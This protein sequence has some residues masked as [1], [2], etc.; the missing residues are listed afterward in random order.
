MIR[1]CLLVFFAL[2]ASPSHGA[3]T[4]ASVMLETV[5][6]HSSFKIQGG[7]VDR[8]NSVAYAVYNATVNQTG[9]RVLS[10]SA[11]RS[12]Q[13]YS[14]QD[15]LY[16]AGLLEGYLT[17]IEIYEMYQNMY[18]T[19]L[20]KE[21]AETI[22]KVKDFYQEQRNWAATQVKMSSSSSDYWYY[23]GLILQ[24]FYGM[25]DGYAIAAPSVPLE[26]FAFDFLSGNGDFLDIKNFLFP[27]RRPDVSTMTKK[28]ITALRS[29]GHC[30]ALIKLLPG[31]E[32]V[33]AAHSSWYTYAA[34][35][36]IFKHYAFTVSRE[37]AATKVM[38]F[39]S[40]PGYLSSLDDFYIMDSGLIMLQTT[41]NI[42]NKTLYNAATP[43]A[44]LAW[45]RVRLANWL[46]SSGQEWAHY[47][48]QYNSGTY[49]NQYMVLDLKKIELQKAVKD[50]V[51]WV[52]EQIPGF[53][54]S[55]DQTAV[56]QSG[57]WAS[58]NVPFYED[59]FTAS[60]YSEAVAEHGTDMSYQLCPRAKIFRRDQGR[61]EDMASM[62]YIMRFN[63]YKNDPYSEGNPMNSIC[64]RG[65]LSEE[66]FLG[67]CYDTKVTDFNLAKTL[68]SFAENGPTHQNLP[69]FNWESFKSSSANIAHL[70]QPSLFNFPFVEMKPDF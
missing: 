37:T 25:V 17:H 42:F 43:K 45:H 59:I 66:P 47:I 33:F 63:D 10:V 23:T 52:V 41:N 60:G 53:V 28:Q 54:K 2:A 39:S 11:G 26:I 20:A 34:M 24:Q 46:A 51:L 65:D 55:G 8:E 44:L 6:G 3:V 5:D 18:N 30:S 49:N 16:A 12:N 62:Q 32:N 50:G 7:V 58:Y 61:V 15:V 67:G 38:T 31:Y 35:S 64:S 9:W 70:G 19:S 69:P 14:D 68:T 48:S 29:D 36:R 27:E 21:S 1:A 22:K 40:Y 57:Y 4:T 56:L 13:T